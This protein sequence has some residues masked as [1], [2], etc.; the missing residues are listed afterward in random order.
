ML[1]VKI[2]AES[3]GAHDN[4][5]WNGNFVPDGWAAVP[6]DMEIPESFPFVDIEVENSVVI[7]MTAR[8][9]PEPETPDREPSVIEQLRADVDYIALMTGVELI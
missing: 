1:I 3:N 8:E 9:I 7:A 6:D 5:G 4:Q 2:A